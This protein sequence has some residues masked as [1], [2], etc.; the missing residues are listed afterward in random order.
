MEKEKISI[1]IP[2]YNA[3]SYIA[4]ILEELIKQT[5][6]NLQIIA[7][8]DG[9]TDKSRDIIESFMQKDK[10]VCLIASENRG[11]SSARNI[12]LEHADGEYIR[13]IDADD[14]LPEDSMEKLITP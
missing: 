8:D 9:S 13:F 10:R 6:S 14:R 11:P 12:G 4:D 2:V 5:Y 3:E 7:V 1:I